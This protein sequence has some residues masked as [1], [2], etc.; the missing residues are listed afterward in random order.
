FVPKG[1]KNSKTYRAWCY[2]R[3]GDVKKAAGMIPTRG[4]MFYDG[5]IQ[6]INEIMCGTPLSKNTPYSDE[7]M[8]NLLIC[9]LWAKLDMEHDW[10]SQLRRNEHLKEKLLLAEE[11]VKFAKKERWEYELREVEED[12]LVFKAALR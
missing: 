11:Y 12:V 9:K 1:T 6:D 8:A 10:V 4:L 2:Y 7:I 5:R 3:L